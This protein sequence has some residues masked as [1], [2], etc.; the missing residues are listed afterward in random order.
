LLSGRRIR[1][2]N[3]ASSTGVGEDVPLLIITSEWSQLLFIKH[4]QS[5]RE[6]LSPKTKPATHPDHQVIVQ[7]QPKYL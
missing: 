6:C 7:Q 2:T 3:R 4:P 5:E 1:C